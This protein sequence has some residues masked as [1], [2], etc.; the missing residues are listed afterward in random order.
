MKT[1]SL[2]VCKKNKAAAKRVGISTSPHPLR[3]EGKAVLKVM[4][5]VKVS[6]DLIADLNFWKIFVSSFRFFLE[7]SL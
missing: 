6:D 5:F 3:A 2:Q 7:S 4:S 1:G